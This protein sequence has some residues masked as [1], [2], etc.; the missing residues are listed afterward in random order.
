[1][2]RNNDKLASLVLLLNFFLTA[3]SFVPPHRY[4]RLPTVG[5]TPIP[6]SGLTLMKATNNFAN[7]EI[8]TIECHL[9]PEGS[10]VPEPLFDGIIMDASPESSETLTFA[11]GKGNYLPGLHDLV[12]T[13]DIAQSIQKK[14]IDAG[15][16]AWNPDLQ[17]TIA[18]E[19]LKG[20]G[21]DTSVIKKGVELVMGNGIRAVVTE[22]SEDETEF[23]VDA[24]PP[25]AGA[26]YLADVKLLSREF[27]PTEF[28]YS[29][30]EFLDSKYQVATFALGCFWGG[31]LAYMREPGVV[32]TKVGYTQGEKSNPSYKEVCSGSTG[33]TESVMILY[34]STIVSYKRLVLFAMDRLGESK[35]LLN[36]VGNDK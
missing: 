10:F 16:G 4:F 34:D 5:T 1:M 17:A 28:L 12:S 31:E 33:H 25:L 3:L 26:S 24:N 7:N 29:P 15:W 6:A 18:F 23:V 35:Y 36:Q 13:M 9:R 20:S 32:G 2:H 8:V 30:K 22:I 19:S 14:S 27:G 21:L 11:L